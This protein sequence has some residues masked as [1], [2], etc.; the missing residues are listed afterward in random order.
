MT[1][2]TKWK[3]TSS[4]ENLPDIVSDVLTSLKRRDFCLYLEGDLGAGKT[5]FATEFFYQLGLSRDEQVP[6]PTFTYLIEYE[7]SENHYAHL[8][9]Y[10]CEGQSVDSIFP[11]PIDSYN[12]LLIEW[13]EK[14]DIKHTCPASHKL[15]IEMI[16]DNQ[17]SYSFSEEQ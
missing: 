7:I 12:G 3:K 13:P 1:K 6:S 10:R 16:D 15:C 11:Y 4:L 9:L 17:R 2:L 8:D 5:S 14:A